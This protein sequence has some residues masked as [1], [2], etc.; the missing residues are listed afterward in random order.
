[1]TKR[2]LVLTLGCFVILSAALDRQHV[3]AQS[4][5]AGDVESGRSHFDRGV[6]YVQDGDLTAALIEFKRAYVAAPNYRVLYNLGQVSNELRDYTEAQRYLQ[7]YLAD[8]AGEIEPARKLEVEAML[9]KLSG[10][11][12]T[13][14]LSTNVEGA[15]VFVDGVSVGKMPLSE[16]VRVSTGTRQVSAVAN[17]MQRVTQIVEPAGGEAIVVRLELTPLAQDE[18]PVEERNAPPAS[19]KSDGPGLV[20]WLGIGTGALAVGTGV[21]AYLASRDAS[22]YHNALGR[23]TSARELDDLDQRASTKALVAD[24]LLGTTVAAAA[25]TLVVALQGGAKKE[26]APGRAVRQAP[27]LAVGPGALQ[28]SGQF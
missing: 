18:L 1:M 8:G 15:E 4:A 28:L 20:L 11:I 14:V 10:R 24:I 5:S 25:V 6:D 16:P 27:Q 22:D 13:L 7:R 19:V 17:G 26:S 23:K 21:M 12:A 2:A 9:A 3:H